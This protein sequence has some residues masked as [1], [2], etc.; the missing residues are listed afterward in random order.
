VQLTESNDV[1]TECHDQVMSAQLASDL[2]QQHQSGLS[3]A[4]CQASC[5]LGMCRGL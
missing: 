1:L 4:A 3:R 5:T 2:V